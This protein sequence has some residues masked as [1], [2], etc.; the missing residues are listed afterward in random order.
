MVKPSSIEIRVRT[1]VEDFLASKISVDVFK[2]E[3]T[4]ENDRLRRKE[5]TLHKAPG[6]TFS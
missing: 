1:L 6:K 5:R 3:L 2:K 4:K